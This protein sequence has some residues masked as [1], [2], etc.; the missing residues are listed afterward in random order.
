MTDLAGSTC[1]VP[2]CDDSVVNGD[3]SDV[4]CGGPECGD[5]TAKFVLKYRL[6]I[7]L[8]SG[9]CVSCSDGLKNNQE[10]DIDCGGPTVE[11]AAHDPDANKTVTVSNQCVGNV[12]QLATCEDGVKNGTEGDTDCGGQ[13]PVQALGLGDSHACFVF[14]DG[15]VQCIGRNDTGQ[16]GIGDTRSRGESPDDLGGELALAGPETSRQIRFIDGG[17]QTRAPWT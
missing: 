7:K 17:W 14:A 6:R 11:G 5:K 9:V 12:C 3:E 15:S 13:T 8:C 16:L 4:D 10:T 2:S 1:R